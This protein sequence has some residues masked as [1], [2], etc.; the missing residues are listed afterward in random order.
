MGESSSGRA[1]QD[2]PS[3]EFASLPSPGDDGEELRPRRRSS[4]GGAS[5]GSVA[6]GGPPAR[7]YECE[8][9][10]RRTSRMVA[11][12]I[13]VCCLAAGYAALGGLL[14]MAVETRAAAGHGGE[15]EV[16]LQAVASVPLSAAA[17]NS[18]AAV[19]DSLPPEVR[20][21]VERARSQ[22]VERLWQVTERMNILYPENW[23]RRASEEMVWFQERLVH[24]F[25]QV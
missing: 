21:E 4:A 2:P 19:L 10:C 11:G 20:A 15:D 13:G 9:W 5:G 17:P 25:A 16:V 22:T 14:F 1:P 18:T 6:G 23:T 7:T 3:I 24:A 12:C 8:V